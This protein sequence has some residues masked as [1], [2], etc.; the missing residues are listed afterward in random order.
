MLKMCYVLAFRTQYV[1]GLSQC[2][3]PRVIA[4][5]EMRYISLCQRMPTSGQSL[6]RRLFKGSDGFVKLVWHTLFSLQQNTAD[7]LMLSVLTP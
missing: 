2:P 5:S 6:I 3:S 1:P 7:F 4:L